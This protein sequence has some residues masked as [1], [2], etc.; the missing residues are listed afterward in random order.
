LI[1]FLLSRLSSK[2]G[3][4]R[5]RGARRNAVFVIVSDSKEAFFEGIYGWKRIDFKVMG[6]GGLRRTDTE[7]VVA[8]S[9]YQKATDRGGESSVI[10][11]C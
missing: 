1:F 10:Y 3:K 2:D 8:F 5:L 11:F 4:E 6:L 9:I 7:K